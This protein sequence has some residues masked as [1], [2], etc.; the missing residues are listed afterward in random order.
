MSSSPIEAMFAARVHQDGSA[1]RRTTLRHTHITESPL[2][3]CMWRLGGERFRA[4]ALAWGH[5]GGDFN[6]AVAGE[7]RNRVA[8]PL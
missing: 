3:V 5:L 2:A 8:G 6:L 7:P 4:A 1:L